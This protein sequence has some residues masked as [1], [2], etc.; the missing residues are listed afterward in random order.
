VDVRSV[1]LFFAVLTVAAD[2]FVVVTWGLRGLARTSGRFRSADE[3]LRAAFA[4]SA[5]W[6]AWIVAMVATLGSLYMSEVAHFIPCTLCWYQRIGMY[7][8]AVVL[9]IAA[10]RDDFGIRRYVVPVVLAASAISI[11]HYQL[12]RFPTQHHLACMADSPCTTVWIWQFHFISIPFM[13]LSAFLLIAT[14]LTIPWR[15][16]PIPSVPVDDMVRER[17]EAHA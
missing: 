1:S 6:F 14:L 11:Y 7:P 8:L 17:E 3:A 12:E 2:I 9:G 10:Y 4:P 15:D 13:A 5:L 16:E